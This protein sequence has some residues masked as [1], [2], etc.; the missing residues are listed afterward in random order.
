ME[1]LLVKN[2]EEK[3]KCCSKDKQAY[4]FNKSIV[5]FGS[6]LKIKTDRYIKGIFKK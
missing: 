3:K 4:K 6:L 2:S 5:F 1:E